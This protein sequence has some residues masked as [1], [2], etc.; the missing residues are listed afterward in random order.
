MLPTPTRTQLKSSDGT[1]IHITSDQIFSEQPMKILNSKGYTFL[2]L[3]GATLSDDA[4]TRKI[5]KD[6]GIFIKQAF[7][8]TLF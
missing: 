4:L 7:T 3:N 6:L 8:R 2:I 5:F 1:A